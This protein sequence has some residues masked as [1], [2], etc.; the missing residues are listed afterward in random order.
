M[1]DCDDRRPSGLAPAV[2]VILLAIV[3]LQCYG[4]SV[5]RE[6]TGRWLPVLMVRLFLWFVLVVVVLVFTRRVGKGRAGSRGDTSRQGSISVK[7]VPGA[8]GRLSTADSNPTQECSG[9]GDDTWHDSAGTQWRVRLDD[10][11]RA[12]RVVGRDRDLRLRVHAR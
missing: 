5:A 8:S 10:H 7:P 11:K 1:G 3:A 4:W 2:G 9:A 6:G 12:Q